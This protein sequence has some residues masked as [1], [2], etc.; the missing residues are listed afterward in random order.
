MSDLWDTITFLS[1][2]SSSDAVF[3]MSVAPGE[4]AHPIYFHHTSLNC[5]SNHDLDLTLQS[6]TA[7]KNVSVTLH[8]AIVGNAIVAWV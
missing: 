1:N 2:I 8:E 5:S 7:D 4:F 3:Y 6:P